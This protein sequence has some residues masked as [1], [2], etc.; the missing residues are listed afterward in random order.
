MCRMILGVSLFINF[1]NGNTMTRTFPALVCHLEKVL[2]WPR[3]QQKADSWSITVQPD[4][5]Q[6]KIAK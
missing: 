3:Q 2:L 6:G 4:F 5:F 1:F